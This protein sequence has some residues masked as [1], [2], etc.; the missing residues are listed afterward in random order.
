MLCWFSPSNE[1]PRQRSLSVTFLNTP[2]LL[3][4]K[5]RVGASLFPLAKWGQLLL[6]RGVRHHVTGGGAS[7]AWEERKRQR[8]REECEDA[9]GSYDSLPCNAQRVPFV[10]PQLHPS[11]P[12]QR[13]HSQLNFRLCTIALGSRT[14]SSKVKVGKCRSP[15]RPTCNLHYTRDVVIGGQLPSVNHHTHLALEVVIATEMRLARHAAVNAW[16]IEIV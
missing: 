7:L 13:V 16:L 10:L 6:H 12:G 11:Q 5:V 1:Y 3:L 8:E 9:W 4:A 2:P 14:Y 15:L